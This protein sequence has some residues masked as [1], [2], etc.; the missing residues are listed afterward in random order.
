MLNIN[1]VKTGSEFI[2]LSDL[3]VSDFASTHDSKFFA[4]S[5]PSTQ[6]SRFKKLR[7]RMPD[8]PNACGRGLT[9]FG[10]L[11]ISHKTWFK[12]VH[13]PDADGYCE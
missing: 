9:R 8:S 1:E 11:F 2:T 4:D 6:E 12:R 13:F 7:I 5:D 3:K 10:L